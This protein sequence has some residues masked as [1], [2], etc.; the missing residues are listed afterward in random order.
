MGFFSALGRLLFA[1]FFILSACQMFNNNGGPAAVELSSKV[2]H[3]VGL[4]LS[5]KGIGALLFVLGSRVGAYLLLLY[6]AI[7]TP[8]LFDFFNL[9]LLKPTF[10]IMLSDFLEHI[11]LFGALLFFIGMKG[12]S[13][14]KHSKK[15]TQ[16][17]KAKAKAH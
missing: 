12:T 9:S 13:P 14:K 7:I 16:K 11:A 2:R 10:G 17:Q 15:K 5:L 8:V 4:S 1:S 3:V 6:L